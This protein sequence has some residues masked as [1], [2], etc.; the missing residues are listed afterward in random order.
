MIIINTTIIT[1]NDTRQIIAR[2]FIYIKDS[3]IVAMGSGEYSGDLSIV[4][5]IIDGAEYIVSPGFINAHVHLGETIYANFVKESLPLQEYLE[6]TNKIFLK[7]EAI[8]RERE[9][10]CDYSLLQLIKNGTTTIAGG[11]T[12]RSGERSGILN[13]SGYMLM[14]SPKL[15]K[16][17]KGIEKQF[18]QFYDS[19]DLVFP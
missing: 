15:G 4:G 17:S 13:I 7:S 5:E 9:I 12:H 16:F 14:Q 10:I 19:V 6:T 8:E 3:E 11:R 18:Q 2:G 1:Q